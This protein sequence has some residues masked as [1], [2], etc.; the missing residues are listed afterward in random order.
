MKAITLR[1]LPRE[2][3]RVVRQRAAKGRL[4]VNKAVIKLLEEHLGLSEK[5]H[6]VVYNDLD[7]LAGSWTKKDALR[8]EK[9]LARQRAIDPE[10]WK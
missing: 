6:S 8:F 3:E 4:S 10:L 1:N 7:D 5:P 9:Y 2:V